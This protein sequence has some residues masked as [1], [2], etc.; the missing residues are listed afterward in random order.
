MYLFI[1]ISV[2]AL[3]TS[4]TWLNVEMQLPDRVQYSTD[5]APICWY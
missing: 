1:I 5:W 4:M 3:L 2:L